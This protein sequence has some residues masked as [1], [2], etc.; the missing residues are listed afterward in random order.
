MDYA[1]KGVMESFAAYSKY[2]YPGQ[3]LN[4]DEL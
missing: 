3:I 4:Y 2:S 1:A